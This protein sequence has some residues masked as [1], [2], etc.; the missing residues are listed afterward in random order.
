MPDP[1]LTV[2][3]IHRPPRGVELRV[4]TERGDGSLHRLGTLSC[5]HGTASD[6]LAVL[7]AGG[8]A[9]GAP[10]RISHNRGASHERAAI[11]PRAD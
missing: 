1:R 6:L 7:R 9:M 4:F 3:A 2:H 8:A 11:P 10:V 5:S